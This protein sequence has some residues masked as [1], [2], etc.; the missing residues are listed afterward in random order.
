MML[1]DKDGNPSIK[2]FNG[3][4]GRIG[5]VRIR[6]IINYGVYVIKP[7]QSSEPLLEMEDLICLI[8]LWFGGQQVRNDLYTT[9]CDFKKCVLPL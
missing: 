9:I 1:N 4:N 7:N 5:P 8:R 2:L 6:D 3:K